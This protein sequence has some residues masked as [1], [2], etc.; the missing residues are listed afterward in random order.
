MVDLER[1]DDLLLR[2]EKAILV[3]LEVAKERTGVF[4]ASLEE[5]ALLAE[6]AGAEVLET[7]VQRREAPDPACYIGKG[8]AHELAAVVLESGAG[9]VI[10]NEELSPSQLRNLDRIIGAKIVDRTALIL[11][12]F[13]RRAHSREGKLQV[14]LAQLQYLLPRLTGLGPQ[15][16]RLGGG[17]GTRGPGETQLEVDRRTIRR[18]I[19]DLKREIG[20]LSRHRA[21]H[22]QQRRRNRCPV[23]GLVGY[24]NAGK[25]TLLNALTGAALYTEDKLFATLDPSVRRGRLDDGRTILFTDT[26]GFIRHLPGQLLAAFQATLEEIAAADILLHVID[27]GHPQHE[28]QIEIV[29]KHLARIDPEL[30]RKELLVFNKIDTLKSFAGEE[31]FYRR[32]YPE[33]AFVSALTG[34]GLAGLGKALAGAVN[35]SGE[36]VRVY[37]PYRLGDLLEQ[38]RRFGRIDRLHYRPGY[39]EVEAQ[40]DA[41]L[42]RQ[43]APFHAPPGEGD[44]AGARGVER[45]EG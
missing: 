5:L 30:Y 7:I 3:G 1:K 12:I 2:P 24:T 10:F 11:D 26:V 34:E 44:G 15:L 39:V 25:S 20:S 32:E 4:A 40:V 43:L 29:R 23:V 41:V 9:L 16:S 14:E 45:D 19:R 31:P 6:T 42:S 36:V 28:A 21:L 18:R 8:K 35:R 13:A 33:A 27:I 37:L 38:I 22:R 17:I